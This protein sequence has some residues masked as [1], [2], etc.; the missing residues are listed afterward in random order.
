MSIHQPSPLLLNSFDKAMI[1]SEG[2]VVYYGSP[3][4][5]DAYTKDMESKCLAACDCLTVTWLHPFM[6]QYNKQCPRDVSPLDYIIQRLS[7]KNPWV[8]AGSINNATGEGCGLRDVRD[9]ESGQDM[10]YETAV[11]FLEWPRYALIH[12][13]DDSSAALEYEEY[14]S[15]AQREDDEETAIGTTATTQPSVE[16][17]GSFE[18]PFCV[19]FCVLFRRALVLTT[20]SSWATTSSL[21]ETLLIAAIAGLCW[22]NT[23]LTENSIID[24]AGFLSFSTTY[25]F[26]SS[27]YVGLMEFFPERLVMQKERDSGSYQLS[28]FFLSKLVANLPIRVFLP[29]LYVIIAYPMAFQHELLNANSGVTFFSIMGIVVLTAQSGESIGLVIGTITSS[30]EVAMT[31]S[32]TVSLSM[33]IFGGFY[34]QNIPSFLVWLSS[35]SALKYSF[36]ASVQVALSSQKDIKCD[37]GLHIPACYYTQDTVSSAYVLDWL[38]VNSNSAGM[39]VLYLFLM[40]VG[41]R[42]MAYLCLRFIPFRPARGYF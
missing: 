33:L 26:F 29:V 32:T 5:I 40:V 21:V 11:W 6:M 22:W 24:I 36:D 30:M 17:V 9:E 1:L 39:N 19:Q 20:R 2:C 27:L 15:C 25:W 13:Y 7:S 8:Q 4:G 14:C 28:A 31:I 23:R 12:L 38:N 41:L 35:L 3:H 42:V 16:S 37:A 10:S 18:L 34:K